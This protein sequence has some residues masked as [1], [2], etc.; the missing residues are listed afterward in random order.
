M[1]HY[2]Y[3]ISLIAM[4]FPP[5]IAVPF[6]PGFDLFAIGAIVLSILLKPRAFISKLFLFGVVVILLGH[7]IYLSLGVYDID[8]RHTLL[9]FL[10]PFCFTV[11]LSKFYQ[12]HPE[13]CAPLMTTLLIVSC[14]TAFLT[15]IGNIQSP[16]ASKMLSGALGG[17][18]SSSSSRGFMYSGVA[19]YTMVLFWMMSAIFFLHATMN[20]KLYKLGRKRS[21]FVSILFIIVIYK[22]A[23]TTPLLLMFM[24]ILLIPFIHRIGNLRVVLRASIL[25]FFLAPLLSGFI[26]LML[27]GVSDLIQS[28]TISPRIE[29]V[30]MRMDGTLAET[31]LEHDDDLSLSDEN[32]YLGA[33]ELRA[34]K[35]WRSF[36][37]NPVIGGGRAGNHNFFVDVLAKYGI[38]GFVIIF[39]VFKRLYRAAV[40]S[41]ENIE[42]QKVYNFAFILFIILGILKTY[43]L[44]SFFVFIFFIFPT[45]INSAARNWRFKDHGL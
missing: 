3:L 35:S 44:L 31:N 40:R 45:F 24:G 37:K 2:V 34:I 18:E 9:D 10:I 21:F 13:K 20:P 5:L 43:S 27:Y 15:I 36:L 39:N 16:L 32:K 7:G 14:V 42:L 30:A 19:S 12:M 41:V 17:D 22:M 29:N 38:I 25:I 26:A 23:F 11:I 4:A 28:P 33:Y 6:V 8:E 1:L